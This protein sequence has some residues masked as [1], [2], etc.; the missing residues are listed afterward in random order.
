MTKVEVRG[1]IEGTIPDIRMVREIRG[2]SN[3]RH[4]EPIFKNIETLILKLVD[5]SYINILI[6]Y[7]G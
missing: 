3:F 2:V 7:S 5:I 1:Y 6:R 4:I